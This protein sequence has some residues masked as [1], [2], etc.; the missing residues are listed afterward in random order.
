LLSLAAA[1]LVG[2]GWPLRLSVMVLGF[3]NGAFTV[4]AI[5]SMMDLARASGDG[6][7]VRMGLW[8][9]AQ[10]IAFGC[11]GACG[12]VLIDAFH[13]MFGSRVVAFAVVFSIEA[14]LF[15]VAARVLRKPA[16][17]ADGAGSWRT[18]PGT[19]SA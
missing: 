16:A 15:L 2:P 9:A 13:H 1:D 12:T 18:V 3:A 10:A 4:G 6:A 19:V 7:G 8:G 14:M 17:A 5:G 11:G